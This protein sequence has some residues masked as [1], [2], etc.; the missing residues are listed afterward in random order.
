MNWKGRSIYLLV[1]MIFIAL[2]GCTKQPQILSSLNTMT[3]ETNRLGPKASRVFWGTQ[4]EVL[5]LLGLLPAP[6]PGYLYIHIPDRGPN[7]AIGISDKT[8]FFLTHATGYEV[9]K[10]EVLNRR[11]ELA[12]I[13]CKA[14]EVLELKLQMLQQRLNTKAKEVDPEA[15]PL[16]LKASQATNLESDLKTAKKDLAELEK[17]LRKNLMESGVV[18]I[19]WNSSSESGSDMN[20]S[21]ILKT[22]MDTSN[23][24]SGFLILGGL[25]TSRLYVG[26]DILSKWN[27]V[28]NIGITTDSRQ[29]TT[30][31]IQAKHVAFLAEESMDSSYYIDLELNY[32]KLSKITENWESLVKLELTA[33]RN[34]LAQLGCMGFLSDDM[35]ISLYR[36]PWVSSDEA[37]EG[38]AQIASERFNPDNTP[39]LYDENWVTVYHSSIPIRALRETLGEK[40]ED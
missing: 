8:S 39:T 16:F 33:Y 4:Y 28:E 10:E 1:S 26:D 31:L 22:K 13:Q 32:D 23:S 27:V 7:A 38:L 24:R 35:E 12:E 40:A 25:R 14:R 9:K 36:A 30:L 20:L 34:R 6:Q 29:I 5:S 11:D 2:T 17:T 15:S 21:D 19:H 18:I 37:L 3:S